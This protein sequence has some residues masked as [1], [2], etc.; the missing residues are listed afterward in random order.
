MTLVWVKKNTVVISST[1]DTQNNQKVLNSISDPC[2]SNLLS[3]KWRTLQNLLC[4]WHFASLLSW[5]KQPSRARYVGGSFFNLFPAISFIAAHLWG[6]FLNFYFTT[7]LGRWSCRGQ[8]NR[9]HCES[10]IHET[11]YMEVGLG[12][13]NNQRPKITSFFN[14]II[15]AWNL[16]ISAH[17]RQLDARGFPRKEGRGGEGRGGTLKLRIDR[18]FKDTIYQS[19]I[20]RA[21]P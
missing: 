19:C 15:M 11:P 3:W 2:F 10:Y 8:A 17:W 16:P 5:Q 18:R 13:V 9:K 14:I 7:R 20:S 12:F 4:F 6:S 1:K 21:I